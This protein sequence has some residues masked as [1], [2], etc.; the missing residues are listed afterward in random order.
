[1]KSTIHGYQSDQSVLQQNSEPIKKKI[2][3]WLKLSQQN[4]EDTGRQ[5]SNSGK[6][7]TIKKNKKKKIDTYVNILMKAIETLW[8]VFL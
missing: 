1:M 4:I 8:D 6:E 7:G 2:Q 5:E 3:C